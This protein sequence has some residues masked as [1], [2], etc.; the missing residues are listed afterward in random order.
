M[1]IADVTHYVTPGD[2]LDKEAYERSTS[3][4]FPGVVIPMLPETL[5]NGTCS[6]NPN[7][8]RLVLSLVVD[9]DRDGDVVEH[10]F[11]TGVIRSAERMTYSDV[12]RIISDED[13][14]AALRKRYKRIVPLLKDASELARALQK[15]RRRRGSIDFD[16]PQSEIVLGVDGA[17][18]GIRRSERLFAH[19]IIEEFMIL[20]NEVVAEDFLERDRAFVY[21]VHEAPSQANVD[22]LNETLAPLG[23]V[24]D[25]SSPQSFRVVMDRVRG[26]PEERFV[27]T[28]CLRN[29]RLA[30]YQ[31]EPMGHFGLASTAYSHFTSPI[32][33]Y[34]DLVVHRL[35]KQLITQQAEAA[36]AAVKL[37]RI[38][39]HCSQ[40]ERVAE[41]AE[42]EY[43]ERK[44]VRFMADKVGEVFDATISGV[45][46]FGFFVE[47]DEYFVDGSLAAA[48]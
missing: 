31:V 10:S 14:D 29:M 40:R 43:V 45:E 20:A 47:L 2:A 4:Y 34:P 25:A 23:W 17:M 33:R 11:S 36:G 19:Q 46:S 5:S 13:E 41:E 9:L 8:D 37:E 6:L 7:V 15:K 32:R 1:H 16:L 3:V 22:T 18:T 27:N 48:R 12:E 38:A 26:K 44:K 42:R 39:E 21:R 30:R 28:V 35:V 24:V